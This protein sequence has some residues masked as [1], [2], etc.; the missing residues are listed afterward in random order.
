MKHPSRSN[1]ALS[2]DDTRSAST[3]RRTRWPRLLVLS[4]C[5]L[6]LASSWRAAPPT[7]TRGPYLQSP[8]ATSI[9]VVFKTSAAAT[10][11]LR[12]GPQQGFAW[13]GAKASP[14][15]TTH[16]LELTGLRPDTRYFYQVESGGA[17]IAGGAE[18]SFHT[19]PC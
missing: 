11:T 17:V 4:T 1:R 3:P 6:L 18:N 2:D 5:A 9:T 15:G 10:T 13:E 7:L 16:V 14:A 12:Y 19:S 8:T